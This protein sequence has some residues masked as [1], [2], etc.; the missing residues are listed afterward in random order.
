MFNSTS[1]QQ[2][3]DDYKKNR[4]ARMEQ[5]RKNNREEMFSKRRNILAS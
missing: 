5:M 2:Y 3:H 1:Q 4:D